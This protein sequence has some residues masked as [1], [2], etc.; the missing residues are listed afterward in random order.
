MVEWLLSL[1]GCDLVRRVVCGIL[2]LTLPVLAACHSA[3]SA[4]VTR[5]VPV[6]PPTIDP[7]VEPIAAPIPDEIQEPALDDL[8]LSADIEPEPGFDDAAQSGEILDDDESSDEVGEHAAIDDLQQVEIFSSS[9]PNLKAQLEDE[10]RG[11]DHDLPLEINNR[12]LGFLDYYQNGRGR[13]VIEA[14]LER[15]GRYRKMIEEILKEEGVPED[16][17][18]L[19]QAESAFRPRA[20]SRARAKGMWQFISARGREYGLR[21]THW[22]D[23]RS[24]PEKS[25]RA[26]ARH[27]KDLYQEF[28]DWYLAMAAYNAGPV[29]IKRAIKRT[30][31]STF[32]QLADRHALPRETINYIPNIL[33]LTIIGKDPAKFGFNVEADAP[34]ETE[35]VPVD[36]ATDLRVIAKTLDLPLDELRELNPHV[37]RWTTPPDDPGFELI[38]PKG[39][40]EEFVAEVAPLPENKRLLFREHFVRSGDTLGAIAR[41]YRTTVAE[42][43]AANHMKR[44]G[45]LRI[46]RTLIV[47]ISGVPPSRVALKSTA[48]T[49]KATG[50]HRL[51][52]TVQKGDSLWKIASAFNVSVTQIKTWNHLASNKLSIGKRLLIAEQPSPRKVVHKVRSGD[53][54]GK[55][56][57]TY[58]TSVNAILSWNNSSDLSVLHPGDQITI[59]LNESR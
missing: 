18:Y 12:V 7:H 5:V 11:L 3:R 47:P 34:V 48:S 42:L 39:Y 27:L 6:V 58:K 31:A 46:G 43:A 2:I 49:R 35:R 52:Y 4:K 38:L 16:L 36:Q 1:W 24:D 54:L 9:D 53:T 13:A 56:A 23:E 22:I 37:L 28:S 30:G 59:Y 29:R 44:N 19:C 20:L 45:I 40:R 25:T 51:T 17:I 57:R 14:G 21:Q 50:T 8:A 41:K 33:A 32:W 55:I 26:A 15:V 10:V